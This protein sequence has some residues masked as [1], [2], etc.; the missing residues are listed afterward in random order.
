MGNEIVGGIRIKDKQPVKKQLPSISNERFE[1]LLEAIGSRSYTI[2]E[3]KS[4]YSFT[5]TQLKKLK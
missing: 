3:A 4:T 5:E 2:Q 1:K